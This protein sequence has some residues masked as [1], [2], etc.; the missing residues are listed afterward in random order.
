MASPNMA[1]LKAM[2]HYI[3]ASIPAEQLG[4]TKLNKILWF[5]DREAFLKLGQ[6]I[7]GDTYIRRPKGP[8]SASLDE[9]LQSLVAEKSLVINEREGEP[10]HLFQSLVPP[11]KTS[12]AQHEFELIDTQV[13]R[14][15]PLSA[16]EASELSHDYTWQMYENDE[17]I[18]MVTVLARP[19]IVTNEMLEWAR[20][21][22]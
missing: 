16:D 19:G 2:V 21:V 11:S 3:V 9:A 14:I 12:L 7:S 8:V 6:T 4:M 15:R 18:D 10:K 20:S 13:N 17:E 22:S 1:K 5:T